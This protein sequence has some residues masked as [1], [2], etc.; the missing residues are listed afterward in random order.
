[1]GACLACFKA[2]KTSKNDVEMSSVANA[3]H[4]TCKLGLKADTIKVAHN[5][6]TNTYTLEGKGTAIG[7]CSLDCDTAFWEVRVGKNPAGV[8]IGVKR[9]NVKKP[10]PLDGL[11]DGNGEG[12]SPSWCLTDVDLV[13][14]DIIGVCWDQTD[15]P[16]VSFCR[17][18]DMMFEGAITRIR[19]ANDVCPAVSIDEGS[20]CDIVFDGE[21]FRK[22]PPSAK[23]SM[24]VCAT[25]L[26]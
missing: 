11:L 7:S 20:T 14:G 13:E 21:H 18:G 5:K 12:E 25:S 24:I 22:P 15:L 6:E 4:T 2:T 23:F 26:I 10:P 1:M 17:N 19:P 16:M 3:L 8:R 9:V